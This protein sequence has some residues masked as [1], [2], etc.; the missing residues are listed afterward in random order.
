MLRRTCYPIGQVASSRRRASWV[1]ATQRGVIFDLCGW[2]VV[3]TQWGW[4][5]VG[6]T[7]FFFFF[8][9]VG[10]KLSF[11]G[12][13]H[14]LALHSSAWWED[15]PQFFFFF[16]FPSFKESEQEQP[17]RET[18][19]SPKCVPQTPP[20]PHGNCYKNVDYEPFNTRLCFPLAAVNMDL[21]GPPSANQCLPC[22]L[23]R[24]VALYNRWTR[25]GW[26][27][28]FYFPFNVD[29]FF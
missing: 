15:F 1:E 17:G 18:E 23:I 8:S 19:L 10:G 24:L 16:F 12:I 9:V 25:L 20:T 4:R 27:N 28:T 6:T 22:A 29:K 14:W 13:C 7:D 26:A 11:S 2:T 21:C 3:N 5:G